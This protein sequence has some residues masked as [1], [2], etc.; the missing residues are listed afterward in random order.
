VNIFSINGTIQGESTWAGLPCVLIRATGCPLRCSW[1]DSRFTHSPTM[2]EMDEDEIIK[3][4]HGYGIRLV[5]LTGGEPLI[6]NA[7]FHLMERLCDDGYTV[8]L[9]TSGAVDISPVD[10]RVHVIMDIKCPGSGMHDRM[11][12]PNVARLRPGSEIKFVIADRA[13]YDFAVDFCDQH[14]VWARIPAL[15]SPAHNA[16]QPQALATWMIADR[17]LARLQVQLHKVIG[18]V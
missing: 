5:E 7:S 10:S 13:D 2:R 1:C 14:R 4:V 9:E 15:F 11:F 16:L 8:L 3:A 18:V 17:S 6:Q 12:I